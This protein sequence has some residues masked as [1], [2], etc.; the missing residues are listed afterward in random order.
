MYGGKYPLYL[1]FTFL[2][3]PPSTYMFLWACLLGGKKELSEN[4]GRTRYFFLRQIQWRMNL[5]HWKEAGLSMCIKSGRRQ[6]E[7]HIQVRMLNLLPNGDWRPWSHFAAMKQPECCP[8][9]AVLD[10]IIR[11]LHRHSEDAV[12]PKGWMSGS[13]HAIPGWS[14]SV[15][16]DWIGL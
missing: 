16:S 14:L 5:S 1:Y 4:E 10:H 7:E 9:R 8:R 12:L 13:R 3:R 6:R 2:L 11:Y 15:G